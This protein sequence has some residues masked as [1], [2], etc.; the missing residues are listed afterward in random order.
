M[1]Y[2]RTVVDAVGGWNADVEKNCDRHF[3]DKL[4]ALGYAPDDVV[5]M[6]DY[7]G[8]QCAFLSH[9]TNISGPRPFTDKKH[10][11]GSFDLSPLPHYTE[12]QWPALTLKLLSALC[13]GE[14]PYP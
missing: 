4:L 3:H 12:L 9:V 7:L 8:D 13:E 6:P 1:A 5:V 2:A 11:Y 10:R 14:A